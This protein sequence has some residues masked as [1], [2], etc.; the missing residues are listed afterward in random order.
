LS[1]K[2]N[3]PCGNNKSDMIPNQAEW[4]KCQRELLARLRLVDLLEELLEVCPISK[5]RRAE[6]MKE[7]KRQRRRLLAFKKRNGL[8]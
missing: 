3:I 4:R 8:V 1:G 2:V 5:E 6:L 7:L